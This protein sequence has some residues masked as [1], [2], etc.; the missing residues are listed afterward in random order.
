MDSNLWLIV[1]TVLVIVDTYYLYN[2]THRGDL[3]MD[4]A[5]VY[6]LTFRLLAVHRYCVGYTVDKSQPL[7][8]KTGHHQ[9]NHTRYTFHC[10]ES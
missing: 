10:G 8:P 4:G 5:Q 1:S 7:N 2:A 9:G 3:S 6:L